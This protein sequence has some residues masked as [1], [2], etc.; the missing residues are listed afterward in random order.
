MK[1]NEEET[2]KEK[3]EVREGAWAAAGFAVVL[4][5]VGLP[6]WWHTTTVYRAAL[7]CN[8]IDT[9]ATQFNYHTIHINIIGENGFK[10]SES[11]KNLDTSRGM[12]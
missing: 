10:F 11:L 4:V 5:V 3:K 7:P 12:F 1:S 8:Q 9:L 2:E 6:V